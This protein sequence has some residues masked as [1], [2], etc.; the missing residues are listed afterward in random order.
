MS[1]QKNS[2]IKQ[3]TYLFY[4]MLYT[5][6]VLLL[7]QVGETYVNIHED[8]HTHTDIHTHTT[9]EHKYI[10]THT[11]TYTKKTQTQAHTHTHTNTY[12]NI[13]EQKHIHIQPRTHCVTFSWLDAPD[14]KIAI[15]L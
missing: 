6:T 14:F 8:S 7:I 5:R 10:H 11:H 15:L 2:L 1:E 12:N 9:K 3:F 13:H 4:C